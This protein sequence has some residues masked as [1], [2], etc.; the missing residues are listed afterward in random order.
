[1]LFPDD[2]D[3]LEYHEMRERKRGWVLNKLSHLLVLGYF[4][5]VV[6]AFFYIALDR[7][8]VEFSA[9]TGECVQV[10]HKDFTCD[11][12]PRRYERV[13]VE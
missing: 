7:P 11:N 8:V 1:M 9:S 13:W 3:D 6:S 5:A 2:Y 4:V 10:L 12:L